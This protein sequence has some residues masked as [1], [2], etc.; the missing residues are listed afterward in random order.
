MDSSSALQVYGS[1]DIGDDSD[2]SSLS[3]L[4]SPLD[5]PDNFGEQVSTTPS[6]EPNEPPRVVGLEEA[7]E[8]P[9]TPAPT[10]TKTSTEATL[11]SPRRGLTPVA[12]T[13]GTAR[14]ADAEGEPETA[15]AVEVDEQIPKSPPTVICEPTD[16]PSKNAEPLSGAVEH[17]SA[18]MD[19]RL[20]EKRE[21]DA[22]NQTPEDVVCENSGLPSIPCSASEGDVNDG[23]QLKGGPPIGYSHS[24][25]DDS[26]PPPPFRTKH[27]AFP[28]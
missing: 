5:L 6:R 16:V 3:N 10:V 1:V 14:T 23:N 25:Y 2:G 15:N 20:L 12:W 24:L 28:C 26:R 7:G 9:S 4:S 21:R 17:P 13:A 19:R 18:T 22:P 27:I 8:Q 11:N